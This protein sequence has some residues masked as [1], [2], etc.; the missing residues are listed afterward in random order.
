[1]FSRFAKFLG[2]AVVASMGTGAFAYDHPVVQN[3][4]M[5]TATSLA[6]VSV[7]K[8]GVLA[9]FYGL[10]ADSIGTCET[11]SGADSK[12]ESEPVSSGDYLQIICPGAVL[13]SVTPTPY[14]GNLRYVSIG[15]EPPLG[16]CKPTSPMTK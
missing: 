16:G 10:A 3:Y 11:A 5:V 15:F 6:P 13:K 7:C 9:R 4:A 2:L 8:P 14:H 1:M 12:K